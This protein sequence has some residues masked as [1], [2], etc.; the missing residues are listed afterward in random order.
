[1]SAS[2]SLFVLGL[3]CFAEFARR[4]SGGLQESSRVPYFASSADKY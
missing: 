1:V 3:R 2:N 4:G